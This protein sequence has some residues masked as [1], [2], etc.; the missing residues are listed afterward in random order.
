MYIIYRILAYIALPILL[1]RLLF[2]SRHNIS[3]RQNILERLACY[4]IKD[5][6]KH[7]YIWVHAVSVGETKASEPLILALLNAY[8]QHT[9]LFTNTTPTGRDIAAQMFSNFISENRLQQAYLP[10]DA[11]LLIHA[12]YRYFKPF[13]GVVLESEIWPNLLHMAHKKKIPLFLVNGRLSPRSY[14]RMH[15]YK[16]WIKP[17]FNGF[18]MIGA[19]SESDYQQYL[20]LGIKHVELTGNIK[21]DCLPNGK[22]VHKGLQIKNS[23]KKN[24][25]PCILLA[26]SREGEEDNIL[27]AW[28]K[29][30]KPCRLIILP[31]HLQRLDEIELLLKKY[32][33]KYIFNADMLGQ[34]SENLKK[35]NYDIILGDSMGE[36]PYYLELC[37]M[38][39]MGGS[40]LPFGSHNL[41]E[42]FMQGKHVLL[43]QHIYNFKEISQKAIYMKAAMQFESA[44]NAFNYI[45]NLNNLNSEDKTALYIECKQYT[46][47]FIASYKGA[48]NKTM[49]IIEKYTK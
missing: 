5:Q 26:S 14:R 48:T 44:E 31:R 47:F 40:W 11:G 23:I 45:N 34:T 10:F 13:F 1:L 19:Q 49:D 3:Y 42:P 33:I 41:L 9:I 15:R 43:G 35:I 36:M 6:S 17:L 39:M 8:P 22:L 7:N 46:N 2:K 21:F 32:N 16:K 20:N 18:K 28:L 38:V 29:Q 27:Q 4:K 30:D 24:D 12:F 37:D 25:K